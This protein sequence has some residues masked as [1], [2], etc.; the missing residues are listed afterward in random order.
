[1]DREDV[2]KLSLFNI[3]MMSCFLI[4]LCLE[5]ERY[6]I[7]RAENSVIELARFWYKS[8]Y[9]RHS[10][11]NYDYTGY[12]SLTPILQYCCV[13]IVYDIA[14][15]QKLYVYFKNW[16]MWL[17]NDYFGFWNSGRKSARSHFHVY[18]GGLQLPTA[19][20]LNDN[21]G[22]LI[23]YLFGVRVVMESDVMVLT[24]ILWWL[25]FFTW[26][27]FSKIHLKTVPAEEYQSKSIRVFEEHTLTLTHH[28]YF[29]LFKI[30]EN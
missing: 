20:N 18:S 8:R 4:F 16:E 14:L 21:L 29:L 24:N 5:R 12:I 17:K 10:F 23:Q 3:G 9:Y 25:G 11:Y 27:I 22:S 7:K 26:N 19:Q 1:M 15:W 30:K 2:H 28:N 6:N 13:K